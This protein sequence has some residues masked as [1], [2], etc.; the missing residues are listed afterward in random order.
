MIKLINAT[1][2]TKFIIFSLIDILLK[3]VAAEP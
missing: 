3:N 1:N 2:F